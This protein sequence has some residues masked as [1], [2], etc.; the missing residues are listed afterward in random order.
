MLS[1]S[2]QLF[3]RIIRSKAACFSRPLASALVGITINGRGCLVEKGVS[4][5]E[6][7][8]Q[9]GVYVPHLCAHPAIEPVGICELCLVSVKGKDELVTSCTTKVENGMI[10]ETQSKAIDR[11]I[12]E[13]L[14][15]LRSK[16]PNE[17]ATCHVNGRC[18]F[19]DLL[20]RYDIR[21]PAPERHANID[22]SSPSLVRNMDKCIKCRRCVRICQEVQGMNIM[23][24]AKKLSKKKIPLDS[25]E[26]INCGQC[27]TVCPVGAIVEKSHIHGVIHALRNKKDRILVAHISPI[28][29][30]AVSEEFDLP[31][32]SISTGRVV[33]MLRMMGFDKVFD[34]NFGARIAVL[35]QAH[36][37]VERIRN[38]GPFPLFTSWCSAWVNM[39]EKVFPEIIPQL[40]TCRSLQSIMSSLIKT[41]YAQKLNRPKSDIVVVS[42]AP[43]T[44]KK[45]EAQRPQLRD[46]TD[47][48]LTTREFGKL[49]RIAN[50]EYASC[51]EESGFDPPLGLHHCETD[52]DLCSVG[53]LEASIRIAY[54]VITGKKLSRIEFR[55]K[56]GMRDGIVDV[57]S[58]RLRIA[59]VSGG[60]VV[61]QIVQAMIE[62]EVEYHVV[63]PMTC[64]DGC[65]GGGGE[66][67]S[68]DRNIMSKRLAH[69]S[70][71]QLLANKCESVDLLYRE[72]LGEPGG[73]KAK[74]LLHTFFES[75][76]KGKQENK[77]GKEGEKGKGK[78]KGKKDETN[79]AM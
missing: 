27:A 10:I 76:K 71:Q 45:D 75:R 12:K 44:A 29:K 19:Q 79:D 69:A 6:A 37:L 50:L 66:P 15:I 39:A 49:V 7:C 9:E 11:Q 14:R 3:D 52:V 4:I 56:H 23:G 18:E 16:H 40:S 73:K 67:K 68:L 51:K 33:S 32:G 5:L 61:R 74:E 22:M 21:E 8:E 57:G 48:V 1:S 24:K 53:T 43:C 28:V 34:A 65:F 26:C 47:F 78:K 55:E 30:V 38:G 70:S 20:Y 58:M 25:T 63:D 13:N 41:Y 64:R 2:F 72:F 31:P 60:A 42:I 35:E 36:Q 46:D 62:G 77:K 17:C 54:E 59:S